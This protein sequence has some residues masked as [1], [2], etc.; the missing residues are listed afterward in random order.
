MEVLG[1]VARF[2]DILSSTLR[3]KEAS[4]CYLFLVKKYLHFVIHAITCGIDPP[5]TSSD[6]GTSPE[7]LDDDTQAL[8]QNTD[9][10]LNDRIDGE[11]D[12]L[13]DIEEDKEIYRLKVFLV[14]RLSIVAIT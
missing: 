8:Q 11:F 7:E 10:D 2:I 9:E 3:V 14:L 1:Q 13:D 4:C 5:G 12:F 6:P